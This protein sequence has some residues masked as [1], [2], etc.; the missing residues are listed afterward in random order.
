MPGNDGQQVANRPVNAATGVSLNGERD[1][2]GLWVGGRCAIA[3]LADMPSQQGVA[4]AGIRIADYPK[5]RTEPRPLPQVLASLAINFSDEDLHTAGMF[6]GGLGRLN[7]LLEPSC[8]PDVVA[9]SWKAYL[10]VSREQSQ[11]SAHLTGVL[12]ALLAILEG[13]AGGKRRRDRLTMSLRK[14]Q[15]GWLGSWR[16]LNV[17]LAGQLYA[18]TGRLSTEGDYLTT[19]KVYHEALWSWSVVGALDARGST[20]QRRI[21]R[22]MRGVARLWLARRDAEPLDDLLAAHDDFT[23]AFQNGDTSPQHFVLHAEVVQRLYQALG[24]DAYLQM[25]EDITA[26]AVAEGVRTPE[27]DAARGDTMFA[28]GLRALS[29]AGAPPEGDSG[30]ESLQESVELLHGLEDESHAGQHSTVADNGIPV[31]SLLAVRAAASAFRAATMWYTKSLKQ[32]TAGSDLYLIWTVR[33]GQA[34]TREAHALR[35]LGRPRFHRS[36]R[37]ALQLAIVDLGVCENPETPIH[38]FYWPWAVL[39]IVRLNLRDSPHTGL[40]ENADLVRRGRAYAEAQLPETDNRRLRLEQ[41]DLEIRLRIATEVGDLAVLRANLASACSDGD[42]RTPAT[43]LIYAARAIALDFSEDGGPIPE[44]DLA[45]ILAV[46]QRLESEASRSTAGHRRYLAS[47]AVTLLVLASGRSSL[48]TDRSMLKRIYDLACMAADT[49]PALEDPLTM[50]QRARAAM[51]YARSLA[52]SDLEDEKIDAVEFYSESIDLF[53]HIVAHGDR[54]WF[55]LTDQLPASDDLFE[56]GAVSAESA[57]ALVLPSEA[58]MTSLLAEAYL[59]RDSL[60]RSTRDVDAAVRNFERSRAA[61]NDSYQL[62]GLLADA[63]YRAGRRRRDPL[64]LRQC[65]S[66]KHEARNSGSEPAREAYSVAA[67]AAYA[68]WKLTGD[69]GDYRTAVSLASW[70]AAVDP[71]W[72]WPPLQLAELVTS[73]GQDPAAL[74]A[75]PPVDQGSGVAA[76]ADVWS[77]A[78][79]ADTERLFIMGCTKAV[80]SLEFRQTV[81]GGRS[82]AYVLEDPHGLLST[83]LVLKPMDDAASA[84][85]EMGNLRDFAAYLS[86]SNAPAWAETVQPL[87]IVATKG[88]PVLATRRSSGRTLTAVVSNALRDPSTARL[89]HALESLQ[90]ALRLLAR[91]HAW[92]GAPPTGAGDHQSRAVPLPREAL[93]K[94][95]KV[96][97]VSDAAAAARAWVRAVPPGLPVLGKRDAHAD[98]WL[99]TDT[100]R[101]VALDL[102]ASGWLPLGFEVAQLLED[103]ALLDAIPD[104]VRLRTE[105]IEMYLTE[106]ASVWPQLSGIPEAGSHTWSTAYAC[107]AAR[108]AIYRLARAVRPRRS[109]SSSGTRA[110]AR[111]ALEHSRRTLRRSVETVPSLAPLLESLP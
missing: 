59:R 55:S 69:P 18:H 94:D 25:A 51:R 17:R 60:V 36:R 30:P 56:D 39:E 105:L 12:I 42:V 101:V 100:G 57:P 64:A 92:R 16:E 77:T 62:L 87:A 86:R 111:L 109:D 73:P 98:N 44:D 3:R 46:V 89:D 38:G 9:D 32:I 84:E 21:W 13:C 26:A 54:I 24:D 96:L 95:L 34:A 93:V 22:G 85:A 78:K 58:D 83:T 5:P 99:I 81:L 91:V 61:G 63:Y 8:D 23:V 31:T 48:S 50:A 37:V 66:L 65:I 108:R 14:H 27:F 75:E 19:E 53:E 2:L 41:L 76:A 103:T 80:E 90:R 10:D 72:P 79:A 28:R 74:P 35:L 40:D 15:L 102:Q 107:F 33:R 110:V 20:A 45:L 82:H 11:Q 67:S 71:A 43:P 88:R 68:L 7:A 29:V 49:D 1:I 52:S 47:H 97:G 6:V 104:D 4:V 106:L 70:A